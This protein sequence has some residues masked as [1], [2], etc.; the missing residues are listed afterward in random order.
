MNS[1]GGFTLMELM[2]VVAILA[3]LVAILMPTLDRAKALARK[4]MCAGQLHGYGVAIAGYVAANDSYPFFAPRP[5]ATDPT[6]YPQDPTRLAPYRLYAY[7]KFYAVLQQMGIAGTHKTSYG[8]WMYALQPDEVW[9]GALC[10]AMD[11]PSIWRWADAMADTYGIDKFTYHRSAVGYAWNIALRAATPSRS[12]YAPRWPRDLWADAIWEVNDNTKWINWPIVL[13]NSD[14]CYGTNAVRPQEID[15]ADQVAEAWDSNDVETTP[16]VNFAG[17]WA[18]E[19]LAPGWHAGP[20]TIGANGWVMLNGS[21][22]P[23]SPNILYADGSVRADATRQLKV[24]DLG[25][26]PSGTWTGLKVN[27]WPDADYD[28]T[29]GTIWHILPRKGIYSSQ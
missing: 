5:E 18:V 22:H 27:S 1:S 20:Q 4:A 17:S 11:A 21:R 15:R 28:P 19:L 16:G 26:C 12:E 3:L 25:V 14:V 8:T 10:P 2:V 6:F 24:S 23:S 29:F 9:R 7:P 13:P